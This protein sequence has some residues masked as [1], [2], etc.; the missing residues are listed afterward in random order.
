M[1]DSLLQ[2]K[3]IHLPAGAGWWPPAPGWWIS[4]ALLT[5]LLIWL[6][7][8]VFKVL[9]SW[10]WQK[11]ILNE[12]N[13]WHQHEASS[14]IDFVTEIARHLRQ[15]AITLFTPGQVSHLT[16]ENWLRFL[17]A[18]TDKP[19]FMTAPGHLLIEAPY[20]GKQLQLSAADKS[21]LIN[22]AK[23]WAEYNVRQHRRNHAI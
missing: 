14:D 13:Q 9:Q 20:Q 23:H 10:Y 18:H 7:R 17:D 8:K 5:I 15:L 22:L 6:I 2:L 12:F 1:N 21:E 11:K 16:G 3:D 4:A 19:G